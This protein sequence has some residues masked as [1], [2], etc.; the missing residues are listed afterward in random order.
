MHLFGRG[1]RYTECDQKVT[2]FDHVGA[3]AGVTKKVRDRDTPGHKTM[4]IYDSSIL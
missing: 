1:S 4:S 2:F 3:V